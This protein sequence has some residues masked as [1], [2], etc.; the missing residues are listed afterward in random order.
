MCFLCAQVCFSGMHYTAF[1]REAAGSAWAL[2]NDA[3]VSP[4]GPWPD[5]CARC[6]AGRWQPSLLF[7]EAC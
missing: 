3:V 1:V 4:A 5:V 7:F 6:V 2:Y